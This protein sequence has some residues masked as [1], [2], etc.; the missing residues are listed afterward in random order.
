M[1]PDGGAERVNGTIF[2]VAINR[3]AVMGEL[4]AKLMGAA[5]LR[6]N[7]E[8]REAVVNVALLKVE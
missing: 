6:A 3:M 2:G 5:R 7:F 8:P 4:Y 1:Q